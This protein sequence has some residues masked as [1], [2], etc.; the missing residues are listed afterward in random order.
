MIIIII[1]NNS[2]PFI[3]SASGAYKNLPLMEDKISRLWPQPNPR[4]AEGDAQLPATNVLPKIS[5]FSWANKKNILVLNT[6]RALSEQT[7]A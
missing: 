2:F 3:K 5:M 6:T 4:L 7:L 1:T